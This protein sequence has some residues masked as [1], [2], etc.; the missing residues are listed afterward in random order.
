MP[1]HHKINGVLCIGI[2]NTGWSCQGRTLYSINSRICSS[3]FL[4]RSDTFDLFGCVM[5]IYFESMFCYK[6]IFHC[7]HPRPCLCLHWAELG[8]TEVISVPSHQQLPAV[9]LDQLVIWIFLCS[10]GQ[11]WSYKAGVEESHGASQL[12]NWQKI[13]EAKCILHNFTFPW[14]GAA[15]AKWWVQVKVMNCRG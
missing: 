7:D 12:I 5:R 6:D 3:H 10:A 11:S 1:L 15:A 14:P 2:L 13:I 4:D 8:L 9:Q